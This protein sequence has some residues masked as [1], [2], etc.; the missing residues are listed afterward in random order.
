MKRLSGFARLMIVVIVILWIGAAFF[1]FQ[2]FDAPGGR[3]LTNIEICER[4]SY[5]FEPTADGGLRPVGPHPD[6]PSDAQALANARV[7]YQHVSSQYWPMVGT[8]LF[9][10][11]LAAVVLFFLSLLAKSIALWVL[12]GFNTASKG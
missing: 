9:I 6:C 4:Y 1:V 8:S 11:A 3:V 12:H 10:T 2:T 7:Q 5:T